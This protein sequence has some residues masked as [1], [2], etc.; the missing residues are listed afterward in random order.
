MPLDAPAGDGE[1][2][3]PAGGFLR[4]ELKA[5]E[6]QPADREFLQRVADLE[7]AQ[8]PPGQFP[9]GIDRG[10][11]VLVLQCPLAGVP[12][13]RGAEVVARRLSRAFACERRIDERGDL[14][15][16]LRSWVVVEH[17]HL[18]RTARHRG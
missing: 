7:D 15:M 5:G 17:G 11:G 16:Q 3:L 2:E 12:E 8:H 18:L 10:A 6:A 9:A 4:V 14:F 13:A 1:A